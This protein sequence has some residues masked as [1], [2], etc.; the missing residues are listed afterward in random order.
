[1]SDKFL[2][3]KLVSQGARNKFQAEMTW[4]DAG[5]MC[6]SLGKEAGKKITDLTIHELNFMDG[7][8]ISFLPPKEILSF[9]DMLHEFAQAGFQVHLTTHS[10]FLL[11][12]LEQLARRHQTD[13]GLLDLRKS[14]G[15]GVVGSLSKLKDGLPENPIIAQS[16][17]LFD[18]DSIQPQGINQIA[19]QQQH[20]CNVTPL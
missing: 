20:L 6:F 10:Y 12:R 14:E 8:R 18:I 7:K 4:A 17:A 5:G 9:A 19:V 11:K 16:L 1:M 13:Y 2:L 15:H 3:G